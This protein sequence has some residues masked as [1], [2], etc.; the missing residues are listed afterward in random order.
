MTNLFCGKCRDYT[1]QT[2]I[3]KKP[4]VNEESDY[5]LTTSKCNICGKINYGTE[6]KR[7]IK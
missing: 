2:L 6:D 4:S 7:D 1:K 3:D 5:D